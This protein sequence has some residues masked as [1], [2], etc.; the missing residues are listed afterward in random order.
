MLYFELYLLLCFC[1]LFILGQQSIIKLPYTIINDI[2]IIDLNKESRT[3]KYSL[4]IDQYSSLTRINSLVER[5]RNSKTKKLISKEPIAFTFLPN[6][7]TYTDLYVD[8][9]TIEGNKIEFSYFVPTSSKRDD[10][11]LSFAYNI[12]NPSFSLVHSLYDKK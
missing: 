3:Q 2:F 1:I 10:S 5:Q 11:G 8:S 12:E 7:K 4:R 6:D 9:L